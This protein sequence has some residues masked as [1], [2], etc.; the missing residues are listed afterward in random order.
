MRP[1]EFKPVTAD[2]VF[3]K[4]KSINIRKAVGC[5]NIP[6]KLLRLAH[7]ELTLPL[8]NLINACMIRSCFPGN[9]KC[10]EVS[11]IYKKSENL[12]KGNFRPVSVLTTISKIYEGLVNDQLTVH[13][14]DIFDRLLSAFRKGYSCQ[15]LLVRFIEDIKSCLDK[16]QVVG[17][18]FMDLSKAFD[19]LP[20]ALTVAKLHAYGLSLPSCELLASYLSNRKQR[21]KISN[22]RSDWI[23]L[24]KGVPQGS[25][26][27]PLLFNV[28]VNDLFL[29]IEK[30]SLYNYADDNSLKTANISIEN[31][32][33][34]LQHDCR[35]ATEWFERNGMQAN[36]EKFQ[37]MI[38]APRS[39]ENFEIQL[40]DSITLKS[41]DCVKCLGVK[42]DRN[43]TFSDHISNCCTKAA[44][45]LN[46]LARISKYLDTSS[47]KIVYTSFIQSN[48][49]YCPLTWHFCGKGNNSKVE[50]IQVRKGP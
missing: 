25:I 9:M 40:N 2:D 45:Q 33:A 19:C 4:L 50:K 12:S 23:D 10:A 21:V 5:D 28:F 32:L 48:F 29:F 35:N 42:I 34:D 26:L 13:F 43:L 24:N 44:R 18:I 8:C 16:N 7:R 15:S 46:A 3:K 36:P 38:L 14:I 47:R 11:P 20:H 49:S 22:S 41:E 27:G 31:V 37:F 1:F 17:T 6:G 39:T 30:C